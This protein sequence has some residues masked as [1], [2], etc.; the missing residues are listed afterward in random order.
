[1]VECAF[2]FCAVF[3][4]DMVMRIFVL[5]CFLAHW[6]VSPFWPSL[7]CVCVVVVVVVGVSVSV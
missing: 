3:R 5:G 1:V 2:S 7:C 4:V 6:F